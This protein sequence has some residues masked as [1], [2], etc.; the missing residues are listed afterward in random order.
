M[1]GFMH[2]V[3]HR[4]V[5]EELGQVPPAMPDS[6]VPDAR[7]AQA[8]RH[9]CDRRRPPMAR[10]CRDQASARSLRHRDGADHAAATDVEQVV[11][12]AKEIFRAEAERSC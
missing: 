5:V 1:R 11:A 7:A 10:A 6:F 8:D 2:L 9:R 12:C 3:R 4:E